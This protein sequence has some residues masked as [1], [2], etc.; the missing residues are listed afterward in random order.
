LVACAHEPVLSRGHARLIIAL[1]DA[2]S[3]TP[4]KQV[5]PGK[6]RRNVVDGQGSRTARSLPLRHLRSVPYYAAPRSSTRKWYCVSFPPLEC[7]AAYHPAASHVMP[8]LWLSVRSSFTS[9][10]SVARLTHTAG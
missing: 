1:P 4:G 7:L 6:R 3:I 5:E 10:S 2:C 8:T 9:L